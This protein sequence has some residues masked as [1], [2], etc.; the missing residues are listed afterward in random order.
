MYDISA[1]IIEAMDVDK[2]EL[3]MGIEVEREHTEDLKVRKKIAMDHLREDPHYYTKLKNAGI[4]GESI[5]TILE[6]VVGYKAHTIFKS[7]PPLGINRPIPVDVL[8]SQ[9]T[10]INE[11]PF[12]I[13]LFNRDKIL[14]HIDLS[15][16]PLIE[17]LNDCDYQQRIF[18]WIKTPD[19]CVKF[20]LGKWE[21]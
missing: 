14:T 3:A 8:F 4:Q 10:R 21:F 5:D 15:Y 18:K 1:I 19:D 2:N 12:R 20:Q 17:E 16:I 7:I 6:S 9:N 11:K 13:T